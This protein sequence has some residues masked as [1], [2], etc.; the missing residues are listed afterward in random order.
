MPANRYDGTLRENDQLICDLGP[1]SRVLWYV[2]ALKFNQTQLR[3]GHVLEIGCGRGDSAL[4]FLERTNA[5]M[6]LLDISQ[7]MLDAA[8]AKLE[9]YKERVEFVC[10]DVLD[11]REGRSFDAVFSSFTIHN[12]PNPA[13]WDVFRKIS[14]VLKINGLFLLN[15]FVPQER[16][17]DDS[18]FWDQIERYMLLPPSVRD[19]VIAHVTQDNTL[20]YRLSEQE[21]L[22]MLN[23]RCGFINAKV[24]DRIGRE[25]L[26]IA[27][28]R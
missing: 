14:R 5:K 8:S 11:F 19:A 17:R 15:D 13:K 25:A 16:D 23:D 7:E 24:V 28:K 18:L 20:A 4:P 6:T 22:P 26:V 3:E 10:E 1:P 21:L 2:A 12:F 27:N 9:A